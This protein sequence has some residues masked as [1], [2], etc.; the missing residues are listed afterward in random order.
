MDFRLFWN[1]TLSHVP[2][3]RAI[4]VYVL[5]GFCLGSAVGHGLQHVY[6]VRV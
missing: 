1:S 6:G 4:W 3:L 5:N 2:L